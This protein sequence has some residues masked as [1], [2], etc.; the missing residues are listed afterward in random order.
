MHVQFSRYVIRHPFR[1]GT[2]GNHHSENNAATHL[3]R[4]GSS[5]CF[6]SKMPTYARKDFL[7]NYEFPLHPAQDFA[8]DGISASYVL[9]HPRQWG[10]E[11]EAFD[12]LRDLRSGNFDN[13]TANDGDEGVKRVS[14]F[15]RRW[16]VQSKGTKDHW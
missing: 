16:K 2:P 9:E 5:I 8:V 3:P 7:R 4:E 6:D 13:K 10:A 1:I 14:S 12:F 15:P 11:R